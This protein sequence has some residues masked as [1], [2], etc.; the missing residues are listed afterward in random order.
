MDALGHFA[1]TLL[2]RLLWTSIQA[3]LLIGI[4]YLLGCL[5]PR[6]SAAMRC[7]LWWLVGAQLLLG[8]LWHAPLELPLLSPTPFEATAP[9]TPPM[10]F[11]AAAA[12]DVALPS[13]A[14]PPTH[15]LSWRT[16]IALSWLAVLLLQGLVALRQ[17]RQARS[18]LRESRPLRDASLQALCARQARQLGLRRCPRLRVSGAIVSPQV[19]GLWRPT[20]LLPAGHALSADEAAMAIAHELAHLRRGDLWLA[21]V[22]A[23]AQC[24]FCFHPLVRWAMRE[25]A[26]NRESACDAQVLRHDRAAPQEYGRLLL[27]LGVAQPMHA[28]LA[29]ASPSFHNLKRRLTMLQQT[30]NQPPSRIRGWLLV[31][32]IALVGVLPYRVTAAGADNT[33]ATPASTQASLLPPPPAPPAVPPPTVPALPPAP[34]APPLPPTPPHDANGLR[35]HYANVAIHTDASEGFALFDGDA[36]IV[37]GSDADLAAAKRLQRNGK[38]MLWFRRGD[39]AWLIDDPAYVQRAKAAYAPVDAL[40]RQQGELGGKQGALGGKQGALGAQQGMLGAQQGQLAGQRAML[41][42]QQAMLAAQS[43]Q[44]DHTAEMQANRAKLEV[45]EQELNRQQEKLSQQ[46]E[47]LGRQQTEIGKQQEALGAQQEALGKRQQQA[48]SQASQQ[49]RKLLDEAIAKGVAKPT[50]LR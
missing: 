37:N 43:G 29:G 48:T 45:S 27:R 33:Q 13:L 22:P 18:V 32:V 3:S 17:W 4:V 6:L 46:Q 14:S 34:P 41:A 7:M 9:V 39:K 23:L 25:Y 44:R 20:V 1:D 36:A 35:V 5:W 49:I 38:S 26:L 2:T 8:L 10:T 24:L 31:A 28:G 16:G 21:W 19:T 50:S 12:G 40:A 15:A 42:N 47:E 11:F 30:V